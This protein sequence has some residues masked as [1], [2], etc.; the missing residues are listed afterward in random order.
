MDMWGGGGE[1][2]TVPF[3]F[4]ANKHTMT[5]TTLLPYYRKALYTPIHIDKRYVNFHVFL[6]NLLIFIVYIRWT[7]ARLQVEIITTI[8]VQ[9]SNHLVQ[10]ECVTPFFL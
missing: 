2:G 4:V 7:P 9:A 6:N 3:L 10:G 1:T 5:I 8:G